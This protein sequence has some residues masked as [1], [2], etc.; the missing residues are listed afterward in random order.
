MQIINTI[1]IVC[2]ICG[3]H[4]PVEKNVDREFEMTVKE[5]HDMGSSS[6]IINS[7]SPSR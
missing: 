7:E 1:E 3:K 5:G 2:S 6:N 4:M